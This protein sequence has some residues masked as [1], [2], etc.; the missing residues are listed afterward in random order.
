MANQGG[1]LVG[2]GGRGG[3]AVEQCFE[4]RGLLRP[5]R[6]GP[7]AGWTVQP[8]ACAADGSAQITSTKPFSPPEQATVIVHELNGAAGPL[9][10]VTVIRDSGT[11]STSYSMTGTVNLKD[12]QTGLTSD[13]DVVG[14]CSRRAS[15]RRGQEMN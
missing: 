9:R 1:L 7:Q 10:D 13:K 8:W 2:R 4:P 14:C 3:E 5:A 6:Q 12:L 15:T 11:F